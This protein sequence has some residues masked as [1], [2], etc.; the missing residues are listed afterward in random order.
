MK[1]YCEKRGKLLPEERFIKQIEE[2][3]K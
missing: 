1:V 3:L 2:N